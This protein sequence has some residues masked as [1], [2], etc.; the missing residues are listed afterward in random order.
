[1]ATISRKK[2]LNL[3]VSAYNSKHSEYLPRLM[4]E[5]MD[6]SSLFEFREEVV[7]KIQAGLNPSQVVDDMVDTAIRVINVRRR[8][9]G[10]CVKLSDVIS[11]ELRDMLRAI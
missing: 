6:S 3:M 2:A 8:T 7:A 9:S 5:D 11:D 1:M 10:Q 4:A